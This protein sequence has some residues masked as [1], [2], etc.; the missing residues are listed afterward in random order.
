MY[1]I[2]CAWNAI[3][4]GFELLLQ[5]SSCLLIND[6]DIFLE[7]TN[8]RETVKKRLINISQNQ[9]CFTL[10]KL[11]KEKVFFL[12]VACVCLI[13]LMQSQSDVLKDDVIFACRKVQETNEVAFKISVTWIAVTWSSKKVWYQSSHAIW[14]R[15]N[16]YKSIS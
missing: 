4:K 13:S 12:T 16:F 11:T 14:V 3:V 2:G 9:L 5:L 1:V 6:T 15:N 8:T 7:A 10:R